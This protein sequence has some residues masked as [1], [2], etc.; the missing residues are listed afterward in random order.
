[1]NGLT[2]DLLANVT[3]T[4]VQA[5]GDDVSIDS[6]NVS[7]LLAMIDKKNYSSTAEQNELHIQSCNMCSSCCLGC[8]GSCKP[9]MWCKAVD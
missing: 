8:C 4:A 5:G 6:I 2:G 9:D 3:D 7:Q 1:M